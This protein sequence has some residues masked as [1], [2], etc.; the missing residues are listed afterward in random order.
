METSLVDE[1]SSIEIIGN[2]KALK[3]RVKYN[4]KNINN[5]PAFKHWLYLM[6][7]EKEYDG[8]ICYCVNC[9]LF[10]YFKDKGEKKTFKHNEHCLH[11]DYAEFCEHCGELYIDTSICC[12]KKGINFF[13]KELYEIIWFECLDCMLYIPFFSLIFYFVRFFIILSNLRKKGQDIN[14]KYESAFLLEKN[15]IFVLLIFICLLYSLI[16]SILFTEIFIWH[17]IY[18]N[19]IWKLKAKDKNENFVRY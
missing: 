17:I 3:Y 8:I 18:F 13:K 7:T 5:V 15:F 4:G 6:K 19:R 11:L 1:E 10:F 16:F 9:F 12:F 14:Y 2:H